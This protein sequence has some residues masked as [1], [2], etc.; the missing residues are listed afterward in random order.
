MK[1]GTDSVLLGVFANHQHPVN[2]LDIGTGSGLLALMMAQKYV[3]A[4]ITGVE[5][6]EE[7]C[8]QARENCEASRFNQQIKIILADILLFEPPVKYDLIIS[9]PPYFRHHK[10]YKIQDEKRSKA[11]HDKDLPFE[12][13]IEYVQKSLNTEGLF[14]LILPVREANDFILLAEPKLYLHKQIEI[15]PKPSKN[16]NRLIMCFGLMPTDKK[17]IESFTI[18]NDDNTPSQEY[19]N[20]TKAFYLWKQFDEHEQLK[21]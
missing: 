2:I 11:R 21:W 5:I 20:T 16:P 17:I 12:K 18:Y 6:D 19:I 4:Q 1:V 13:L 14:W 8:L 7:A 15:K 3:H 10:S 9:N